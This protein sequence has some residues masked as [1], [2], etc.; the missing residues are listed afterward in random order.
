MTKTKLLEK[1]IRNYA[2]ILITNKRTYMTFLTIVLLTMPNTTAK[3]IGLFMLI[4]SIVGF[5]FEIP[6]GYISDRLGHRNTI[7]LSRFMFCVSTLCYLL[8][9]NV[10]WFF[11]GS[12]FLE[13]GFAFFS[14]TGSAFMHETLQALKKDHLYSKIMGRIRSLGF[15]VPIIFILLLPVV[16][17]KSFRYA[18]AIAL[19]IDIV[20][21]LVSLRLV[22]PNK[23]TKVKEIGITNMTKVV[24]SWAQVGWAPYV[25]FSLFASGF[26]FGA[27]AGFKNPFQ[28][29]LGFSIS[30]LG[31]LWASS[32]VLISILLLFN[33]LIY[34]IFSHKNFILMKT[35][36]FICSFLL[37]GLTGD[38]W[39]VA[40]GFILLTTFTNGLSSAS[41]HYNLNYI[42]KSQDKAT[43][44]SV[45]ALIHKI[46]SGLVG[47]GMGVLVFNFNYSISYLFIATATALIFIIGIIYIPR[48][49]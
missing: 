36:I 3:T 10:I 28:E 5:I 24:R 30:M 14:G 22:N 17:E 26:A 33:G 32:R 16:A 2:I 47:L 34:K 19:A 46:L 21:F 12:I 45:N 39:L 43:L 15:A 48:K 27:V 31:V 40:L 49:N 13:L 8:A 23:K 25:L 37:I 44:L 4:G 11:V 41:S 9:N 20:G 7:I 42:D 18:F 1:N 6:S 35:F 38:K 29:S